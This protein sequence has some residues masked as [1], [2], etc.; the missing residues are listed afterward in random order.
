MSFIY[1]NLKN[2][3]KKCYSLQV[4]KSNKENHG[5]RASLYSTEKGSFTIEAAIVLPMFL[6]IIIS[7]MYFIVIMNIQFNIQY[8]IEE[9]ARKIAR[10]EYLTD[11]LPGYSLVTLRGDILTSDF[12]NYLNTTSIIDGADGV[13]L[14][15]SSVNSKKAIFDIVLSYKIRIPLVPDEAVVLPFIQRCR[16]K[17]WTGSKISKDETEDEMVFITETGQVYHTNRDCTHLKLSIKKCPTK[18]LEDMRNHNGG[19]YHK[20]SICKNTQPLDPDYIYITNEGD[21]WHNSTECSGLKRTIKEIKASEI[22]ARKLCSRCKGGD[23]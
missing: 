3:L 10:Q 15:M 20:C 9:T 19:I 1:A 21:R 4:Q 6:L 14:I 17:T 18:D 22:G 7:I 5:K 2:N 8:K 23:G 16:F 13:S 12:I 11:D